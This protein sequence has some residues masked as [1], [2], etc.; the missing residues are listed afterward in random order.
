MAPGTVDV[1]DRF[2]VSRI[3]LASVN[4]AAVNIGEVTGES[5]VTDVD[6]RRIII[7]DGTASSTV[8]GAIAREGAIA[9]G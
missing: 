8:E 5:A 9:D 6:G 3:D 7:V 2:L 4:G 1:G